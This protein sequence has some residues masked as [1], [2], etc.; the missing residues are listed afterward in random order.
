M[1]A[2]KRKSAWIAAVLTLLNPGLLLLAVGMSLQGHVDTTGLDAIL[3]PLTQWLGQDW[4]IQLLRFSLQLVP[5]TYAWLV[6]A[7]ASG[8]GYGTW[9]CLL[10]IFMPGGVFIALLLKDKTRTRALAPPD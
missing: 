1:H 6:F 2:A 9:I 5:L 8:K 3:A 4:L 7:L 10:L